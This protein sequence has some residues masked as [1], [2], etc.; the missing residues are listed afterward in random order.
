MQHMLLIWNIINHHATKKSS[1]NSLFYS[2]HEGVSFNMT[3]LLK[4]KFLSILIDK[5]SHFFII[6][7]VHAI[8]DLTNNNDCCSIISN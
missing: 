7:N 5:P 2:T 6:S 4:K 1:I 8:N 3:K